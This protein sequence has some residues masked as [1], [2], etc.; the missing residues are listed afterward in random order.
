MARLWWEEG[1]DCG[2]KKREPGRVGRE[3]GYLLC[4]ASSCSSLW[5]SSTP[6][7]RGRGERRGEEGVLD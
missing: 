6:R 1:S 2:K 5:A 4:Q 7:L 3:V